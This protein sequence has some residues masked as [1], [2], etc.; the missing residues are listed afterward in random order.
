MTK[1]L[2]YV[3][4]ILICAALGACTSVPERKAEAVKER[5]VIQVSDESKTWGQALNMARN[6]REAYGPDG[7]EVEVVAFGTGIQ[8]LKA[9]ALLASRVRDT[10]AAGVKVYACGNSMERFKLKRDDMVEG[11]T[12]VQAGIEHII[13]RFREGWFNVKP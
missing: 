9:D 10:M 3:L 13:S 5:V 6:L 2:S 1:K 7:I 11:L 4:F 8:M 12:H